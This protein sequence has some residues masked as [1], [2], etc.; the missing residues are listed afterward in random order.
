MKIRSIT[1]DLEV[2]YLEKAARE[3]GISRVR[4]IRYVMEKVIRDELVA[5]LLG[6]ENLSEAEPKPEHY[7][8]FKNRPRRIAK[9]KLGIE[10]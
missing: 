7:R 1:V 9:P 6:H 4:L 2:E 5:A 8:R 10:I 3:R